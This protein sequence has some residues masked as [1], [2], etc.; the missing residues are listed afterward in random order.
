M[1]MVV[2]FVGWMLCWFCVLHEL[3]IIEPETFN[4]WRDEVNDA[5]VGK[6]KALFQVNS[7]LEWL[8]T[9]DSEEELDE[10]DA[11]AVNGV[12]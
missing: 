2:V 3:D 5:Y 1:G 4:M 12:H 9:I 11:P 8:N 10:S 7:W 6:G